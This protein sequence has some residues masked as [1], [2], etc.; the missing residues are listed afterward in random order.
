MINNNKEFKNVV[1]YC[2]TSSELQAD[3]FSISA[4]SNKITSYCEFHNYNII[5]KYID[6]CKT[7]TTTKNRT[8]FINLINDIKSKDNRI[9][10]V[11]I[12]DISR[13]ARNIS[14]LSSMIKLF[15]EYNI[16]LIS[17]DDN[18]NTSD[19]YSRSMAYILGTFAELNRYSIVNTC[20]SGMKQRAKEGLWN[21]GRIFGYVSNSNKELEIVPK[22]AK[23]IEEIFK[24]Y[25][26]SNWGYKKIACHL[27]SCNC[28]TLTNR[29]W[30]I[31]SIKQ[32]IDNPIYAGFIRWGQYTDWAKKRRKGKNESYELYEGQHEA[33]ISKELWYKAQSIRNIN[34]D[35][36]TKIYEGDFILTGLIR[37]PVC[38]ASMISHRTKKKNKS[39]EFYRYYQCSNFFNKGVTVCK[40]NLVN[41]D[42]AEEYV[43]D[44]IKQLINSKEIISSLI[45]KL[46]NVNEDDIVPFEKKLKELEKSLNKLSFKRNEYMEN[47]FN[48]SIT[49]DELNRRLNFLQDREDTLIAEQKITKDKLNQLLS[50]QS[51]DSKKIISILKNFNKLFKSSTIEQK[52]SL[53]HSIIASI[54]V[55]EGKTTKDRTINKIKLHF[56]PVDVQAQKITKKFAT[57]CDTVHL[58]LS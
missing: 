8:N 43:L 22:Q 23:I 10:A 2:R 57:T 33:I 15:E 3:N 27:N 52:K 31:Q 53:L 34:K 24:L 7:G 54:S 26:N 28:K 19:I 45:N 14:D 51:I 5:G 20:R 36:F 38:G 29:S 58:S 55:H 13:I 40:S 32:I 50:S 17:I 44:K 12:C 46:N 39:N 49:T 4:Q 9:T 16:S 37:C 21:G 25:T 6:E 30:A 48:D 42:I 47:H 18:I 41:A 35:K 11:I 1:M 56:E